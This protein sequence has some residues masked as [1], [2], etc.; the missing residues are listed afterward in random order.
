MA[1]IS[2]KMVSDKESLMYRNS[3]MK[4]QTNNNLEEMEIFCCR[5]FYFVIPY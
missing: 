5:A 2:I 1:L 4:Y 3:A